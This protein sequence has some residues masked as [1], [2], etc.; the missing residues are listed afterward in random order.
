MPNCVGLLGGGAEGPSWNEFIRALDICNDYWRVHS[1]PEFGRT[2]SVLGDEWS[3]EATIAYGGDI[4]RRERWENLTDVEKSVLFGLRTNDGAW[5]LLGNMGVA[6]RAVGEFYR[7]P[8]VRVR[9]RRALQRV[10]IAESKGRSFLPD[11]RQTFGEIAG[12]PHFGP[13]IA[14]RL[15]TLAR[16]D[17][18]ISLNQGSVRGLSELTRLNLQVDL[19]SYLQILDWLYK[20]LWY[21]A[22]EPQNPRIIW[23]MR[24]ALIDCFVYERV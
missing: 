5:D 18:C 23:S 21:Q 16:P 8:E 15:M 24:A 1:F 7:N 17:R 11:A 12:I 2:F 6:Q 14:T 10:I 20:Q 19:G 13:A 4:A 22:G 3:W 9:I